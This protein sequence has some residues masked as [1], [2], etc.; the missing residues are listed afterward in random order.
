MTDKR[1]ASSSG[2]ARDAARPAYAPPRLVIYGSLADITQAVGKS[3]K[4]D[5][6]SVT[7]MKRSQ[8]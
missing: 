5:G 6:G 1:V 2:P 3:S 8:P 7:G 4:M